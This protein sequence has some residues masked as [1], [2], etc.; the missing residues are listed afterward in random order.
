MNILFAL[1]PVMCIIAISLCVL[2]TC[3]FMQLQCTLYHFSYQRCPMTNDEAACSKMN[4]LY[5]QYI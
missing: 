2:R 5:V 4:L 3:I 1:L